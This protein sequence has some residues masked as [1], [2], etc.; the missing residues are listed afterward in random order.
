MKEVDAFVYD[1]SSKQSTEIQ[2]SSYSLKKA[3]DKEIKKN[4]MGT[5]IFINY[6][7]EGNKVSVRKANGFK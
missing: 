7:K 2:I 4:Y 1:K 6:S 3:L 5:G